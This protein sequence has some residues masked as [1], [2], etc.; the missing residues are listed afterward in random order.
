M[1]YQK[2]AFNPATCLCIP[3]ARNAFRERTVVTLD[4]EP[5]GMPGF[6]DGCESLG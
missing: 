3:D 5:Y 2:T 4:C 1:K 6:T